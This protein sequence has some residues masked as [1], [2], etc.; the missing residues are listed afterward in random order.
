MNIEHRMMNAEG[1]KEKT[2][3]FEIPCS[4]FDIYC[5][6]LSNIV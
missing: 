6:K 2:S 3:S 5:L 4:I 1:K